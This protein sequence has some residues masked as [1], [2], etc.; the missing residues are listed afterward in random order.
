MADSKKVPLIIDYQAVCC[1]YADQVFEKTV[2][3]A[4]ETAVSP[5]A[6]IG[7]SPAVL[8]SRDF[9]IK[10]SYFIESDKTGFANLIKHNSGK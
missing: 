2:Q 9:L 7:C 6:E 4:A 3:P 1:I 8:S 10:S 5:G